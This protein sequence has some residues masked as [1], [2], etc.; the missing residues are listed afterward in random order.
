M[1]MNSRP[2]EPLGLRQLLE[3]EG[4]E[5]LV[6]RLNHVLASEPVAPARLQPHAGRRLRVVGQGWPQLLAVLVPQPQP[7][8]VVVTPAGLL[9]LCPLQAPQEPPSPAD[10]E[11]VVDTHDPLG[12]AAR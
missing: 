7:L 4:R 12:L 8:E 6:L 9:E 10:L 2:A 11:V 5:R 1:S 3:Q